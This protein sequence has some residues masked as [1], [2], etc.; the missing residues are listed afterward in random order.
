MVRDCYI[1]SIELLLISPPRPAQTPMSKGPPPPIKPKP[2]NLPPVPA[3][4]PNVNGYN[5]A[6]NASVNH[7]VLTPDSA[8]D[9]NANESNVASLKG[10][11]KSVNL[12]EAETSIRKEPSRAITMSVAADAFSSDE[13]RDTQDSVEQTGE[14]SSGN[15]LRQNFASPFKKGITKN[16]PLP[17]KRDQAAILSN[18]ARGKVAPF[19]L[20]SIPPTT[21]SPLKSSNPSNANDTMD[22]AEG[23]RSPLK[24]NIFP[25]PPKRNLP[26]RVSS[27]KHEE[28]THNDELA[29]PTLPARK[30]IL[31]QASLEKE[32]ESEHSLDHGVP[33]PL[34]TRRRD[35]SSKPSGSREIP[36]SLFPDS[37]VDHEYEDEQQDERSIHVTD[38]YRKSR[39]SSSSRYDR[40][41]DRSAPGESVQPR[42]ERKTSSSSQLLHS[43]KEKSAPLAKQALGG[44][45]KMKD[46]LKT[47]SKKYLESDSDDDSRYTSLRRRN[48]DL[49]SYPIENALREKRTDLNS[50]TD[51]SPDLDTNEISIDEDRPPLPTRPAS[52]KP[53]SILQPALANDKEKTQHEIKASVSKK[54]KPI[55][56]QPAKK[57]DVLISP[58]STVPSRRS[59]SVTSSPSPPTPPPS[60]AK[61]PIAPPPRGA[62][63]WR[64]P[65][66]DLELESLW[67]LT[68]DVSKLPKQLRGLNY[69]LSHGYVGP[70]EFK[71]YAFRLSDLATLRLKLVWKKDCSNP[72]STLVTETKFIPPPTATK[73]QLTEGHEKFGEHVANWCEVKEGQTVGDGECWTL[74]HDALEKSCGKYAFVSTGLKHGALIATYK[75]QE[76]KMPSVSLPLVSDEIRRGDI[77]QF[78]TCVFKYPQRTVTFGAPDHT[79]IVL[80]VKPSDQAELDS[81]LKWLEIIHQN[82][83]GVKKVRVSDIDLCRLACGEVSVYRP[84]DSSWIVDLAEVVI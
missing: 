42:Y 25:P 57:T 58:S 63:A 27:R 40:T 61:A 45:N 8:H 65:N 71:I 43:A 72:E 52:Q 82:M 10:G 20:A 6:S 78:K 38:N 67:Y 69:Q 28:D 35:V 23:M 7:Q 44:I 29:P 55:P 15:Q 76:G 70:K 33:P 16:Y 51:S 5:L 74:A 17:P 31:R 19:R 59:A 39:N 54:S 36:T 12:G 53:H 68:D 37:D 14:N 49:R 81:K 46:K 47:S 30:P 75:G 26:P 41:G 73:K 2:R 4:K 62:T 21:A 34:P 79:A 1:I 9:T 11:L 3:K 22:F 24:K 64:E 13:E 83:G 56:P 77:L 60:R 66:I 32:T 80:D 84:V 50:D 48:S 18:E